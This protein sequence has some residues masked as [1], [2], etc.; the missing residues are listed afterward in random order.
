MFK[1]INSSETEFVINNGKAF[2][3]NL[4]SGVLY[5]CTV[6]HVYSQEEKEMKAKTKVIRSIGW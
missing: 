6:V 1:Y 2:K 5:S 3:A 4:V